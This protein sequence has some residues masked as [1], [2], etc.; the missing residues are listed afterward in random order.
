MPEL[1]RVN[2]LQRLIE[3]NMVLI[4]EIKSADSNDWTEHFEFPP[5][6][7]VKSALRIPLK[8]PQGWDMRIRRISHDEQDERIRRKSQRRPD[9]LE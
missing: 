8:I 5:N 4:A 1:R 7:T 3:D 2:D 6:M 9:Y